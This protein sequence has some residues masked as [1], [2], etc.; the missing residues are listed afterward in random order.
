M[1]KGFR[2]EYVDLFC[3]KISEFAVNNPS[4]TYYDILSELINDEVG[5]EE[6]FALKMELYIYYFVKYDPKNGGDVVD[7][8][9]E[10]MGE[11]FRSF[12][13]SGVAKFMSKT[14]KIN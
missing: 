12:I 7:I 14:I 5:S 3:M 11:M 13:N 1:N 8:H 10:M 9:E 2:E 4:M 6:L